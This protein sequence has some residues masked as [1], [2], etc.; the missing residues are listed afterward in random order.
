M[1]LSTQP[2]AKLRRQAKIIVLSGVIAA[3]LSV[4]FGFIFNLEYRAEADVLVISKSRYGVD[5]Y[6]ITKSAERIGENLVAIMKT[7]DFYEK[8]M[9]Q[10]GQG[11]DTSRFVGD[12]IT[13]RVRRKRWQKAVSATVVY[14][15]G[16]IRVS[17]YDEGPGEAISLANAVVD[18]LARRGWEY[19]GGDVTIKIVNSPVVGRFPSRPN[20]P[21]NAV[22][23]F[24][25]GALL[26]AIAVLR[27]S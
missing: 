22:V 1:F 23:A 24:G 17:A 3:S 12:E 8:V 26:M 21:L 25:C 16:V 4:A 20:F 13:E 2:L 10:W 7:S 19:V 9:T 27:R 11:I 14:G 5:P 18:T 15:T 6:T